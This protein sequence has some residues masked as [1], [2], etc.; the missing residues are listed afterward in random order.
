MPRVTFIPGGVSFA[1]VSTNN[2]ASDAVVIGN[3][4]YVCG[5]FTQVSDAGGTYARGS[6]ACLNLS[7]AR[8][9]SFNGGSDAGYVTSITSDGTYLYAVTGTARRTFT[10]LSGSRFFVRYL[11]TTGVI[12]NWDVIGTT[13]FGSPE[14]NTV[15][16]FSGSVYVAGVGAFISGV[17]TGLPFSSDTVVRKVAKITSGVLT[18]WDIVGN[19]SNS[20]DDFSRVEGVAEISAGVL[21]IWGDGVQVYSNVGKSQYAA[22]GYATVSESTGT[23]SVSTNGYITSFRSQQSAQA[24]GVIYLP[25]SSGTS[26]R[27]LPGNGVNAGSRTGTYAATAANGAWASAWDY[28]ITTGSLLAFAVSGGNVFIGGSRANTPVFGLYTPAGVAVGSF[29]TT[30]LPGGP[31]QATFNAL[32]VYGSWLIALGDT[33]GSTLNGRAVAGL[34]VF[35]AAT[36]VPI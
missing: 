18:S 28:A 13:S 15:R 26:V 27:D 14:Y 17:G 29:A 3:L 36:G 24:S 30:F 5:N 33:N 6:I 20:L 19:F 4:L 22:Y 34:N 1:S 7:T 11:L 8:W 21:G 10:G 12:E 23:V 31:T 9:T 35:D 16:Y 25:V 32:I 2:S